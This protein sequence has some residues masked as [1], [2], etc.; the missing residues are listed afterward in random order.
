MTSTVRRLLLLGA[1]GGLLA[2]LLAALLIPRG[3]SA[4]NTKTASTARHSGGGA[5]APT[6]DPV[7]P[8]AG[9]LNAPAGVLRIGKPKARSIRADIQLRQVDPPVIAVTAKDPDGG[10]DW[11]IR[12]TRVNRVVR[13][14]ARRPG[15]SPIVGRNQCLQ[16]GRLYKDQFGWLD[17]R[18]TFRP[19]PVGLIGAPWS[20][21]SAKRFAQARFAEVLSTVTDP[22][23]PAAATRR[24]IVWGTGGSAST[25]TL[26]A[27]GRTQTLT[28][29]RYSTALAILPG[30]VRADQIRLTMR[31]PQEEETLLP[32]KLRD[33]FGLPPGLTLGQ[34]AGDPP[35]ITATAPDPAGG[36][37][38]GIVAAAAKG[39]GWC[40]THPAR[41]AGDRA[42]DIDYTLDILRDAAPY[43]LDCPIRTAKPNGPQ[44]PFRLQSEFGRDSE[45]G[46]DPGPGRT[47]R[48][49]GASRTILSG[50]V[51]AN[52]KSISVSTAQDVRTIIPTGAAH[53][54]LI[55]Y[56]STFPTGQA[57]I[58]TTFTDGKTRT[59]PINGVGP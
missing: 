20:C 26:T 4:D 34:L 49:I 33:E 10:P 15:V 31:G 55:V 57:T 48:R 23:Q 18:G 14:G 12:V 22:V 6:Q 38:H 16:L 28:H 24:T 2:G 46:H 44:Q 53:G 50:I 5:A 40:V 47:A 25:F 19:V 45:P 9:R 39:G 7:L 30:S 43:P 36:L 17:S 42:G 1:V 37:P 41:I 35:F 27:D 3:S 8:A 13:P 21:Q 59:D 32:R 58:T 29:G 51:D 56:A 11:A 52:V 54:F